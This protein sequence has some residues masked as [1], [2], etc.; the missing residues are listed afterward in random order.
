[1][2]ASGRIIQVLV[3]KE[4]GMEKHQKPYVFTI[5]G[6]EG[7]TRMFV[8]RI[9]DYIKISLLSSICDYVDD[10]QQKG[11]LVVFIQHNQ[12]MPSN[13]PSSPPRVKP[14]PTR[15]PETSLSM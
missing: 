6:V 5:E 7:K 4:H 14:R 13:P 11:R 10:Y 2:N 15:R 1:M 8:I 9:S 12:R 3:E